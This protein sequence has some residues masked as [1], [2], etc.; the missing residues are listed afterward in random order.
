MRRATD[1]DYAATLESGQDRA[2]GL[3]FAP[4]AGN[5]AASRSEISNRRAMSGRCALF[6]RAI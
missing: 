4:D 1:I 5:G 6:G 2:R 3:L